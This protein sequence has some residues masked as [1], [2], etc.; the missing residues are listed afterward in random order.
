MMRAISNIRSLLKEKSTKSVPHSVWT[1]PTHFIT[2]VFGIGCLPHMPGTW[3]TLTSLILCTVLFPLGTTPYTIIT[4]LL[5]L[6]GIW[7]CEKTNNDFGTTD[8]PATCF[9]KFASFPICLIGLPFQWP[10]L[11][12]AF[13]LFRFFDIIKPPPINII[14]QKIHGGLGVMLDD[15]VAALFTLIILH[16]SHL[17]FTSL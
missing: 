13:L 10:Y 1:N 8:H 4:V 9:D 6:C 14:D 16:L 2:C 17:F 3:A 15:I 12:A 7:L 11:L 5:C